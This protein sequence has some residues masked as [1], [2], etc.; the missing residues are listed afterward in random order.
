VDT[1]TISAIRGLFEEYSKKDSLNL[2]STYLTVIGMFSVALVGSI[3]QWLITKKILKEENNR[4]SLQLNS[5]FN[6]QRHQ[7]WESDFLES[8]TQLLKVT[9]PEIGFSVNA[10]EVAE[11]VI[12]AQLLLDTS[13]PLQKQVNK[14]INQLALTANESYTLPGIPDKREIL[15]LHGQLH[16]LAKKLIYHPS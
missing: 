3:T 5:E 10:S 12:K 1:Q 8:L 16:D 9:D 14:L 6:F 7:K 13:K 4:L 11:K 15:S 2:I